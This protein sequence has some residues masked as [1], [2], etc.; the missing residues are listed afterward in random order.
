MKAPRL[1]KKQ[2][3]ELQQ[4]IN[5]PSSSSKTVKRA[6]AV[7]LIDKEREISAITELTGLGRSQI[8]NLRRRYLSE[9][10]SALADTTKKNP[11]ALLTKPERKDIITT[12]TT[13]TPS[14]CDPFFRGHEY[15]TT[16]LLGEH[17][18]RKYKVQ[19]KSKTSLYL[20]FEQ[21]TF[22]FH[23]PGRVYEKRNEAEVAQWKKTALPRVKRAWN[24][25][26][27]V[28]LCEDEMVLSTQTTFQ[29]IWLPRGEY[30]K[31]E[32]SNQKENRSIYGFLNVKTGAEHAFKTERQNMYITATILANIQKRYPNK[33][34]LLLWDG[35]GW[36]KG[37][38]V[39]QFVKKDGN[40][41][42]LH[43]PKYSPEEN[44][45]EH[46]WKSGR[47]AITHN[48]TIKDID[49]ATDA[50]VNYLN[51][52]PFHYALLGLKP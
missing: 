31:I 11:K 7:L 19:Y 12:I 35:P 51:T 43:F 16:S 48:V 25:P 8:F 14:Q 28:I 29:K 20:L 38:V 33:R 30:P 37:S 52:T 27:T 26:H 50:F 22:T 15:W 40:I 36:H 18:L 10:Q 13:K 3:S 24:D 42:I 23:K 45:Q 34:I 44:P 6:Q 49:E 21:S 4:L 41:T 5:Q 46:V 32:A 39:Q 9:G 1:N 17:I 2:L 47:S